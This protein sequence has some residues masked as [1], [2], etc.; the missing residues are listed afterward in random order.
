[1]HHQR[2]AQQNAAEVRRISHKKKQKMNINA[3]TKK[4]IGK[5]AI[6]LGRAMSTNITRQAPPAIANALVSLRVDGR[7]VKVAE[8]ATLLDAINTSGSHVPTL[9]YH[10]EFQ[11]KAVCRMCL[12]NVK[13]ANATANASKLLPACRTK[14]E[15]GQ[16]VTTNSE[17]IKAFRRRD[18]QFLLNRHPNDCM[19][20]EAAGNCKLQSL[21]QEECVE[22]MWPTKTSR[23]SDEHPHLL[24]DHTSP[25]IWRDMSKCIECGLC[26][27]ACSAQKINAIGF[28][29]RGSGM[30]PITAFD[31]PL[32]ETG[33]ISCGQ[34]ILRCPVGALI[35]R[36]DWHRVLDVLDDRKRTTIVQTA[37]ATRVAIGE[38]FGLEPGSVSTGRMI[39]ALRELGFDY[40]TDTNFSADLTIMEE[41]HELLQRL[42][43]KREGAL[44]LFTSCC[45]GWINYVEINRPDLIP[46][47]STTKSPQQM[48]GA[49]ARNGPMAK[50]IA[51]QT[52]ESEE[53]YIVSIM[54]CTAKKDESVR[55]GNRGDIDAVLTTRELAKLIRHRDIPF[56]SLSNDG[57]Y[58]SPMGESSGAGAI[59]GAS[60][61]VLEAAL[62]TAADTLGLDGSIEHE[63]L[64]GVDRGIKVASIKGVGSV[65]AVSSI[66]SAIELLNTD[67]WKKFL[68]IEVMACPGGCLGGGGEPKSDDKDILKRRM[69]GIYS[70]DKNAP[71]RKSHENKEVQ[72][73]YKDFLSFPLSEISER[74]L[75]TSYAPRGSPR[76]KLSRFLSAVDARDD[77]G[78]ANL[79]SDKCVWNTNTEKFGAACGKVDIACLIREKL[80]LVERKCGEEFPRHRLISSVHGTDVIGPDGSKHHFEIVLDNKGLIK[81]LTRTPL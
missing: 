3:I 48:H 22:D 74:L 6:G 58:D 61:G 64:R 5:I 38:E 15:E 8:G 34:C 12:V 79:C 14:V 49:I 50:Q 71:I 23:G 41:A 51:A 45:P 75:H 30:L 59:F 43:G 66:G 57:E 35:E 21:V 77:E 31:K 27:D 56:A 63:Q 29:E 1:M 32:S 25:S 13:E 42:Q 40:V 4:T 19:R 47:L 54:P 60:G 81:G 69:A 52:S 20:C 7:P 26:V 36:P 16:E 46:H 44:P 68:M 67:H 65:A 70:I 76:E 39:N 37:P 17:D 11:P 78:A 18:L 24:L 62:R 9:C 73:L 28:A 2:E 53:P 55:P 10:P 80:P 72:Q 33:C